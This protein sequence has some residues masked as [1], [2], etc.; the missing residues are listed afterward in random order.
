MSLT[1]IIPVI[2]I[3]NAGMVKTVRYKSPTYI[4]DPVNAIRIFNEKEVDEIVVLDINA[5]RINGEP[6]Y[7][8]IEEMASEAFMPLGY[9]GGIRSVPQMEKLF[10][11]GIEKVIINSAIYHNPLLLKEASQIFGSQSVVVAIDV[12]KDFFGRYILYSNAGKN[13]ENIDL[14]KFLE[15]IQENGAGE[16]IVNSIDRDGTMSGYDLDLISK[17]AEHIAVPFVALG[18]AGSVSHLEQATK[19]GASSVAAGS[20]FVFQGPHKAVLISY[21]QDR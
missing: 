10:R 17:I 8:Y 20:M 14:I 9:G 19:A 4:G 7:C 13:K 12:K 21:V 16:I 2:L 15:K 3:S 5:T 6:N 11:I 1:R 18:G